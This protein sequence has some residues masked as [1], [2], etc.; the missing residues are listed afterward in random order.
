MMPGML[1]DRVESWRGRTHVLGAVVLGLIMGWAG[2]SASWSLG[3]NWDTAGYMTDL[4]SGRQGP[5]ALPWTSHVGLGPLFSLGIHAAQ[6]FGGTALD[7]VRL[8]TALALGA[9]AAIHVDVASRLSGSRW[10]GAVATTLFLLSWG[11][12][13][14]VFT[15]EDNLLFLPW[16]LAAMRIGIVRGACWRWRDTIVAGALL[17]GGTLMSWQAAMYLPPVAYLLLSRGTGR[18]LHL[19]GMVGTMLGVRA[20]WAACLIALG[21]ESVGAVIRQVF[22]RP[23]PSFFPKGLAG[24]LDLFAHWPTVLRHLGMGVMAQAGPYVTDARQARAVADVVGVAMLL[25]VG[26]LIWWSGRRRPCGLRGLL[27]GLLLLLLA[28]ALY[29]DLP[30]DKHKRYDFLP[31]MLSWI[32]VAGL[33]AVSRGRRLKVAVTF[34]V[35]LVGVSTW[36]SHARQWTQILHLQPPGYHTREGMTWF[37]YAR[38]LRRKTPLAC[39]YVFSLDEVLHARYQL[40]IQSALLSELPGLVVVGDPALVADWPRPLPVTAV[41]DV[42]AGTLPCTW[43][44]DGANTVCGRSH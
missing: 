40:E 30:A 28:S 26:V 11:T 5:F 8:L 9:A 33:A 43:F 12:A 44:S 32:A 23:E 20:L 15:W 31:P 4:A 18:R 10:L 16:V 42:V 25:V 2:T 35:L 27:V 38:T 34:F 14:L 3:I 37:G 6:F 39:G 36:A 22:G 29:L 24:W 7:G 17:G 13:M 1:A 21:S 41:A 19:V